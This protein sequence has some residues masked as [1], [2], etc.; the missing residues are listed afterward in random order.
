M[1]RMVRMIRMGKSRFASFAHALSRSFLNQGSYTH[2]IF[3]PPVDS[4]L[5]GQSSACMHLK[6]GRK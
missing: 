4:E 6:E 1:V 5:Y 2:V 3:P